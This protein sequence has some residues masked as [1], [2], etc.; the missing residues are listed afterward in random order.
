MQ[1]PTLFQQI[2]DK[3]GHRLSDEF[4]MCVEAAC[5]TTME[6]EE[7]PTQVMARVR[8]AQEEL[9]EFD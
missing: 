1:I 8:G 6:W 5:I 3:M 2:A 7:D 9:G 4:I